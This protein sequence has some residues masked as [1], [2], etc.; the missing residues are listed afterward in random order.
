MK[1]TVLLGDKVLDMIFM[2]KSTETGESVF[3]IAR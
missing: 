2:Y 1:R 3:G